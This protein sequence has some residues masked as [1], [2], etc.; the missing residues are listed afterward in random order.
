MPLV[1]SRRSQ[2]TVP[3]PSFISHRW[4]YSSGHGQPWFRAQT[5]QVPAP[6]QP[7]RTCQLS[8]AAV[9]VRVPLP[10]SPSARD[11]FPGAA[12]LVRVPQ[13]LQVPPCPVQPKRT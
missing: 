3:L 5:L 10:R 8:R 6:A 11:S 12:V 13:T 2:C 1:S 4:Q 9:L 7:K